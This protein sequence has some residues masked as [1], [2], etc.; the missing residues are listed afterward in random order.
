MSEG[1]YIESARNDGS[2]PVT[3]EGSVRLFPESRIRR[4]EFA[5][6]ALLNRFTSCGPDVSMGRYTQ[7]S[8]FGSISRTDIGSF[9]TLGLR[10]S[11][12]PFNHPTSW[13]SV[14]EFQ[15]HAYAFDFMEEYREFERLPRG[16]ADA[17]R[18]AIG[19]D[20]WIGNNAIVLAGV[21]IG[22]GA[23]VGAGSVVTFDVPSYTVVAG[24]PAVVK[25]MRFPAHIVERLE[26]ARWWELELKHL[27]GLPFNDV[28]RCLEL[29]ERLRDVTRD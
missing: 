24:V 16:A 26:R 9:C 22:N 13:L 4:S 7:L 19:S 25:K 17:K 20:V 29:L 21:T 18:A 1:V 27:S 12:N 6:P 3:L 5:G 28:E 10:A 8:D 14:H 2:E 11:I 15:Y 23:V